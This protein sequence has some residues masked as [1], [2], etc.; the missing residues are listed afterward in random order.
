MK[1]YSCITF[2]LAYNLT[3]FKVVV[4][5]VFLNIVWSLSGFCCCDMLSDNNI[6]YWMDG[7]EKKLKKKQKK[8]KFKWMALQIW[9]LVGDIQIN[10]SLIIDSFLKRKKFNWFNFFVKWD[11]VRIKRSYFLETLWVTLIKD[12]FLRPLNPLKTLN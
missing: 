11:A 7:V 10:V 8:K 1:L 4:V 2:Y 9:H 3:R 12:L 6:L 5:K